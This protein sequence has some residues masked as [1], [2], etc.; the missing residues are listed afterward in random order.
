MKGSKICK[1]TKIGDNFGNVA[2]KSTM[3]IKDPGVDH[4]GTYACIV[5][6]VNGLSS[7]YW[8]DVVDLETTCDDSKGLIPRKPFRGFTTIRVREFKYVIM[9][10]LLFGIILILTA[11]MICCLPDNKDDFAA[12]PK[13]EPEHH[14]EPEPEPEEEIP[15]TK[16][17]PPKPK[18]SSTPSH[19][20][21]VPKASN[22]GV[23]PTPAAPKPSITAKPVGSVSSL[24]KL[25]PKKVNPL[26]K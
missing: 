21:V 9:G 22:A 4:M 16:P 12:E 8:W 7:A 2:L 19:A 20:A 26:E 18:P 17:I 15:E 1:K 25:H 14:P 10:L 23:T 11:L 24:S 6:D 13:H 3:S 5:V